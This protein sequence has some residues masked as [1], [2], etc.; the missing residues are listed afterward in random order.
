MSARNLLGVW[1]DTDRMTCVDHGIVQADFDFL[2]AML[3]PGDDD[4][5][6]TLV[7]EDDFDRPPDAPP[8][9]PDA[10][11]RKT[12]SWNCDG[13]RS[14]G[15]LEEI[16]SML[17]SSRPDTAFFWETK[18][19]AASIIAHSGICPSGLR[20]RLRGLGYPFVYFYWCTQPRNSSAYSGVMAMSRSRPVSV[21]ALWP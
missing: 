16:L 8:V 18:A 1:I 10:S 11:T 19:D 15:A 5:L 4:P 17:S 13:V 20:Q 6:G 9:D 2:K 14:G 7:W 3:E 12:L 21:S